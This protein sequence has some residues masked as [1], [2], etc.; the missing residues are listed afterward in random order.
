MLRPAAHTAC[1]SRCSRSGSVAAMAGTIT[2]SRSSGNVPGGSAACAPRPTSSAAGVA[3][4]GAEGA[5]RRSPGEGP[6]AVSR[7]GPPADPRAGGELAGPQQLGHVL[8]GAAGGEPGRIEAAVAQPTGRDLG[9]GRLDRDVR[10]A[11]R[12]PRPASPG[13]LLHLAGVEQAAAAVGGLVPAQQAPADVGVERGRLDA[14]PAGRLGGGEEL[15]H[16]ASHPGSFGYWK[17][18]GR[19][20]RDRP[21]LLIIINID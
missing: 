15:G 5:A 11:G 17:Y 18:D 7:A 3:C 21:R 8:E 13:Q 20:D 14:E 16:A 2:W 19:R 10:D 9:N 1:G 6:R 12:A 4:H